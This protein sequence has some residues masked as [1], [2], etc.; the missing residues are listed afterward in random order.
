MKIF[1]LNLAVG[2]GLGIINLT[3]KLVLD[4]NLK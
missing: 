1:Q 4:Q 3:S 2:M